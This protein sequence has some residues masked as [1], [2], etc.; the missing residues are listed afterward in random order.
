MIRPKYEDARRLSRADENDARDLVNLRDGGV[1]VK[2]GRVDPFFGVNF[3]HRVNRSQ[4]GDWRASNGQ[5]LC[6]SGTTGCHGW[7]TTEPGKAIAD[8]WA[9]P[10]YADPAEWPAR[11]YIWSRWGTVALS[12]VLYADDGTWREISDE[13]ARKRMEGTV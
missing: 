6:G 4:G 10:G 3:D 12:W 2:C 11:R 5:L 7:V 1:C 13:E 8:G 9:C